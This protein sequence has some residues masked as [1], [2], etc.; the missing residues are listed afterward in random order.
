MALK[1]LFT[2]YQIGT[3]K[4]PNR[5]VVPAMVTNYCTIEGKI[6]ERYMKYIEE[7]AKGGWGLIITEDYAVQQ[8]GK[9]YQRIPGLYKDELIEGNKQLTTMVH[10]YESKIFCQMYHPGRQTTR[11][12]NEDHMPVAPSAIECPLCQ[13]QPRDITVAEINQLVKDFGSAAK[14]V[15]EA[16]FDGIE[17]HC[18]HGYLLAEFLSPFVNK[19]VDNYGGCLQNRVRIVA[20]IYL[21]MRKQVGDDFPIIVRLSGNEYVHGGRTEAETYEL[22]MIF[23][24]L[25]FDGIHISNG[26]YASPGNR[27]VIAPMFTEHA[28]NMEISAQ[29]KKLVDLPVIVTNRINDPQMADTLIN[30]D[31]ADFIGMGRGSLTDP[32]LP[33]KAKAEKYGNIKM[34]IGC[35]QGCEMPLFF[36]QEVTCLVNP[37]VG[38]EYENS[39]DIVEKAKKVMIVGGGP[40]GLQAAETAAMI[41][42]NVTVYEAQEEVGGQFRSAAYPIGKGELTTLISVFKKNL[43]DLHVKVHLNTLVT[44]EMIE[45]E[46]PDAIILATGARPLVP[47]VKGIDKENVVNAED[48][49]LGKIATKVE[50]IVVCGG[51]EV[52]CETATF[53]AQTHRHVTVL[54]MKPAVLTDM[55][56]INMSCL[57]PIMNESGVTARANCTVTE[58]LDDGVAFINEQGEKEVI[59][60][61][62]VVLAFGYKAY[63]PLEK[64]ANELC[65]D[66]QVVGGAIKAGNALPAV[67][68]GYEA[69]LNIK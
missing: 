8:Y 25:G 35:L 44:K 18:A 31:K 1:K 45:Q 30:M 68:E 4:I 14:R 6:T 67:K 23:E 63:N 36:N 17:L 55:D 47:A 39:M 54:E 7:K 33:N 49:L 29:V 24:E 32:D 53:I 41:G 52:G 61:D 20:E 5:L 27:A 43:E 50:H 22:C 21:E 65:E 69:A 64:I 15:K 16:G 40:A 59:S 12:A 11:I 60:A 3:V 26:S 2:P 58:I 62:L 13:E 48:V 38:R 56:P 9:G 42:H 37:R 51:G 57:L 66:V 19:R 10:K 28:L 34:C 46:N